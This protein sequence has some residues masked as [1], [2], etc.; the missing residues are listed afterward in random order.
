MVVVRN[1]IGMRQ[2]RPLIE[3]QIRLGSLDRR[4]RLTLTNRAS[5]RFRMILGR[6]ALAGSFIVDVSQKYLLGR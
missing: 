6:E 4:I 1:S 5:M 3:T 2:R